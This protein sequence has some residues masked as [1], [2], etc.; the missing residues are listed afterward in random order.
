MSGIGNAVSVEIDVDGE[1]SGPALGDEPAHAPS[2]SVVATT[3]TRA[4]VLRPQF[5]MWPP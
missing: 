2:V 4:P 3:P 1:G 5:R